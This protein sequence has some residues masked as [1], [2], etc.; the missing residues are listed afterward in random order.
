MV[1]LASQPGGRLS[2]YTPA[3]NKTIYNYESFMLAAPNRCYPAGHAYCL[4]IQTHDL[5]EHN[6][7]H[8]CTS[9]CIKSVLVTLS[10]LCE[11][12][13]EIVCEF[14]LGSVYE[15]NAL[16]E[17]IGQHYVPMRWSVCYGRCKKFYHLLLFV[18]PTLVAVVQCPPLLLPK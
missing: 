2:S 4:A 7:P 1:R 18:F 9:A 16:T 5:A 11:L 6:I 10:V 12:F 8:T 13:A 15:Y 17:V 3:V 14:F